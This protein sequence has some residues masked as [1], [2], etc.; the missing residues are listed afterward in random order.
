MSKEQKG[1]S[2]RARFCKLLQ[3][4]IYR[5]HDALNE[6]AKMQLGVVDERELSL[7]LLEGEFFVS[8]W[9]TILCGGSVG[10]HGARW[11]HMQS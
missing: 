2:W 3:L 1:R 4:C 11:I 6:V 5:L 10:D 8:V 7:E 9:I